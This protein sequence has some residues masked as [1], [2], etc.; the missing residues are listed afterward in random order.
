MIPKEKLQLLAQL[1][2]SM[3]EASYELDRAL[4]DNDIARNKR[5]KEFILSIQGKIAAIARER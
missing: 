1:L 3:Q 5:V 2:Q 4:R